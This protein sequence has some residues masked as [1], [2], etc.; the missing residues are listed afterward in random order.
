MLTGVCD[1][2]WDYSNAAVP[3]VHHSPTIAPL[4]SRY[5]CPTKAPEAQQPDRCQTQQHRNQAECP[6]QLQCAAPE[7][8]TRE[9]AQKLGAG[10]A[11]LIANDIRDNGALVS[12]NLLNNKI[13]G[14]MSAI[15][16]E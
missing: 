13:G 4:N 14:L 5:R 7:H 16:G 3:G 9:H 11:V 15:K 2:P 1:L 8:T 12:A 6:A 10:D